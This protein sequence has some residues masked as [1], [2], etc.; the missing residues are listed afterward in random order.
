MKKLEH[1]E[2]WNYLI[3]FKLTDEID[4]LALAFSCHL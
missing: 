3:Y 4:M 1:C 2:K